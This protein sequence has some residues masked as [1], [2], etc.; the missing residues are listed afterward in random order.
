[1]DLSYTG[2]SPLLSFPRGACARQL[3]LAWRS[4][5]D[6]EKEPLPQPCHSRAGRIPLL[7]NTLHP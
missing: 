6:V 2:H 4:R 7:Q 5:V 1:M 3:E